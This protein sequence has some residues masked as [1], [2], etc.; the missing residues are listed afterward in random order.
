MRFHY[1]NLNKNPNRYWVGRSFLNGRCWWH[2]DS[3]WHHGCT[4]GLEWSFRSWRCG[5]GLHVDDEGLH[6]SVGF[7]P[8]ALYLS[9]GPRFW[10]MRKWPKVPLSETY[11]DTMV[12]AEREF[13]I[14]IHGG[15]AWLKPWGPLNDWV[16]ADPWW[17]R[18]VSVSVDPFEWKFQRHEVRCGGELCT[19][20]SDH[21]LMPYWMP[22]VGSWEADKLPDGRDVYVFPYTYT[23]KSGEVQVRTAMVFVSRMTWRPLCLQWTSLFEKERTTID[24]TF[25]DEVGERTGSWKGGTTGC[26]YELRPGETPEE[27]LRRMEKE[28]KF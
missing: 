12:V 9:F 26:S 2:F 15:R 7:P 8:I 17:R 13:S 27:C 19:M 3:D 24:V 18:G 28:R 25:S 22:F 23:L 16:K 10:I 1:Q 21:Y 14:A 11:P 5:V 6:F 4:I 20:R